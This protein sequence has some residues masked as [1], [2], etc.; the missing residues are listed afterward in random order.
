MAVRIIEEG[1]ADVRLHAIGSSAGAQADLNVVRLRLLGMK[2]MNIND[3]SSVSVDG[4]QGA[5]ALMFAIGGANIPRAS[6]AQDVPGIEVNPKDIGGC[7]A[8]EQCYKCMSEV[9]EELVSVGA[10]GTPMEDNELKDY[11]D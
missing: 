8:L 6:E 11:D 9:I 4:S 5:T 10:H 3:T 2:P 1:G 7:T